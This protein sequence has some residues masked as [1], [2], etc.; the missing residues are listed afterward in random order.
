MQGFVETSSALTIH[1]YFLKSIKI[2]KWITSKPVQTFH[3]FIKNNGILANKTLVWPSPLT[4]ITQKA[5]YL[6][7]THVEYKA[8]YNGYN[9]LKTGDVMWW[10]SC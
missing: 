2:T 7:M 6:Y 10:N 3:I 5:F 8:V 1:T 4:D 9:K